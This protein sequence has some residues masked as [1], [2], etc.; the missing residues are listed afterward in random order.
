MAVSILWSLNCRFNLPNWIFLIVYECKNNNYRKINCIWMYYDFRCRHQII[1]EFATTPNQIIMIL[2]KLVVCHQLL[3][4]PNLHQRGRGHQWQHQNHWSEEKEW[5]Q[6]QQCGTISLDW[7][8]IKTGASATIVVKNIHVKVRW[9][10]LALWE[11]ILKDMK[12]TKTIK[13]TKQF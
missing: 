4:L 12:S 7:R 10:G 5:L 2:M 11:T 13:T 6:D 1:Q 8:K 9:M 3:L